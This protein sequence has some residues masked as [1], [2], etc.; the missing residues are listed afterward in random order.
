MPSTG[1]MHSKVLTQRY[2]AARAD[3]E[4]GG[5][6]RGNTSVDSLQVEDTSGNLRQDELT[7]ISY[8][9]GIYKA[10]HILCPRSWLMTG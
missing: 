6:A 1:L 4:G 7:R 10:L 8:V 9:V 3:R 2:K 5:L